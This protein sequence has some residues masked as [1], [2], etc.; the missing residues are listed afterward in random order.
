MESDNDAFVLPCRLLRLRRASQ[1]GVISVVFLA[2]MA[3]VERSIQNVGV[4]SQPARL[5]GVE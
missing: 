2:D 5:K 4:K 3:V 1:V